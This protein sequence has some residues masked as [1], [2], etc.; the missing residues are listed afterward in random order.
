MY[1]TVRKWEDACLDNLE[2][3]Q[4]A[5]IF[6]SKK[7]FSKNALLT[8]NKQGLSMPA[9]PGLVSVESFKVFGG[10]LSITIKLEWAELIKVLGI[11]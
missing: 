10:L 7:T 9:C 8:I 11:L 4:L 5:R 6:D 1:A 3:L 2:M